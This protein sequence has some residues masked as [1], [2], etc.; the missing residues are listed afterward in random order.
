MRVLRVLFDGYW[1]TTLV[2]FSPV[3]LYEAIFSNS[4]RCVERERSMRK[5]GSGSGGTRNSINNDKVL[6]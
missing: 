4:I 5:V 6:V 2:S 3:Q 1:V